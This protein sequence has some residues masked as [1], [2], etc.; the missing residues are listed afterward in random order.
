MCART[1]KEERNTSNTCNNLFTV[2]EP[3]ESRERKVA[4]SP[5]VEVS[6][7]VLVVSRYRLYERTYERTGRGNGG[8]RSPSHYANLVRALMT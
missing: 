8:E 5:G 4:I 7:F 2:K 1:E 3:Y 6:A